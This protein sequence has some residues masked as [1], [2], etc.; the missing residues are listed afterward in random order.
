MAELR[1]YKVYAG[2]KTVYVAAYSRQQAIELSGLRSAR[3]S[4][5]FPISGK[6]RVL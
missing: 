5:Q 2:S 4:E 3:V 1:K 6:P